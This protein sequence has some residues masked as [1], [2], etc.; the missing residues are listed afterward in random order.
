LNVLSWIYDESI[1]ARVVYWSVIAAV[2][3]AVVAFNRY[4]KRQP[5]HR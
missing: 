4:R 5:P 1:L 2:F 3:F